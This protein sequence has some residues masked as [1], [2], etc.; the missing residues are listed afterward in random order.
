MLEGLGLLANGIILLVSIVF[1]V[2][3]SEFTINNS[4]KISEMTGFG[5]TTIGFVLVGMATSLPELSVKNI[6]I[7]FVCF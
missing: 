7:K 2:V 3:G 5:K 4:V 6:S 1:L